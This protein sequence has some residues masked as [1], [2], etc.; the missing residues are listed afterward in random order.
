M[1]LAMLI[2]YISSK[3]AMGEQIDK[4][5]R[6]DPTSYLNDIFNWEGGP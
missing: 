3:L 5:D 1:K 6:S 4:P 2:L